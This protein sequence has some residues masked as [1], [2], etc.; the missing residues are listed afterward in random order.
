MKVYEG[1]LQSSS[2]VVTFHLIPVCS[3]FVVLVIMKYLTKKKKQK[4]KFR[5]FAALSHSCCYLEPIILFIIFKYSIFKCFLQYLHYPDQFICNAIN[6]IIEQRSHI[7]LSLFF[8][9]FTIKILSRIDGSVF[10]I[11]MVIK[12]TKRIST[13]PTT[14]IM[15]FQ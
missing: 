8:F 14:C 13:V 12:C 11:Q 10:S 1:R 3:V 2:F 6:Y 15:V 9:I 7:Y 4:K 5:D